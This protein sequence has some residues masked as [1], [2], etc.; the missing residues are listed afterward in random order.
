MTPA[1]LLRHCV[2]VVPLD[3]YQEV[4]VMKHVFIVVLASLA[5]TVTG[6]AD[7]GGSGSNDPTDDDPVNVLDVDPAD[8]AAV[9]AA[10]EAS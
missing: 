3:G 6:C 1:R 10:C 8:A 9:E 7:S 5:L 2:A 4:V